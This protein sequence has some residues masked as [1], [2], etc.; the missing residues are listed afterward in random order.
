GLLEAAQ[1][2]LPVGSG[3]DEQ[4]AREVR[5]RTGLGYAVDDRRAVG[6]QEPGVVAIQNLLVGRRRVAILSLRAHDSST[7]GVAKDFR[8][9]PGPSSSVIRTNLV[10]PTGNSATLKRPVASTRSSLLASGCTTLTVI[11]CAGATQPST[12][13]CPGRVG[14]TC[15]MTVKSPA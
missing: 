9:P 8:S 1:R 3:R 15:S 5:R 6:V 4:P 11:A 10:S 13:Q 14:L 12:R 2:R 7:S